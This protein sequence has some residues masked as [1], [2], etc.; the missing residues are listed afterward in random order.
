MGHWG[1]E[2]VGVWGEMREMT[3][4]YKNS[5]LYDRLR[6]RWG[7]EA[8]VWAR[9]Q[10]RRKSRWIVEHV[11]EE[12]G[13]QA[14]DLTDEEIIE[15]YHA[16]V[17]AARPLEGNREW[18]TAE[19][20]ADFFNVTVREI[21]E[22]Y[23]PLMPASAI[24]EPEKE[25]EYVYDFE[26][27]GFEFDKQAARAE[28]HKPMWIRM[29]ERKKYSTTPY[30]QGFTINPDRV[31]GVPQDGDSN[32]M[33]TINERGYDHGLEPV[34]RRLVKVTPRLYLKDALMDVRFDKVQS[35]K[36]KPLPPRGADG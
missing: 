26:R 12:L 4:D 35:R 20:A 1:I 32:L 21:E 34:S 15:G 28:I 36:V 25:Y 3:E 31:G 18:W 7:D 8:L 27:E 14:A 19:Q 9:E 17:D 5:Y 33:G 24:I 23:R 6:E 16:A 13:E 2:H 10:R 22:R 11:R 30:R 29:K